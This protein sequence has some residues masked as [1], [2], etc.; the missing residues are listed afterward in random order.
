MPKRRIEIETYDEPQPYQAIYERQRAMRDEVEAGARPNSILVLEH[1]PVITCG[2]DSDATHLLH[3]REAYAERGIDVVDTD[4]GGDVTYHGP[5]QLTAYP[6]LRLEEWR[7]SIRWYLRMLEETLIRTLAYFDITAKRNPPY[8]GVWVEEE[9]IAQ[10]GIAVRNWVSYH[11]I[12]LNVSPAM[13]HFSL[14]IPCGIPDKPVTSMLTLSP[15]PPDLR[16]VRSVFAD[17]FTNLFS[18]WSPEEDP[19]QHILSES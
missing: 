15:N 3:S 17:E 16:K 6:I 5:G 18:E 7:P 8:T 11:G 13:D 2:R 1:T 9:K 14:I 10:V 19:V 12:A 4:R